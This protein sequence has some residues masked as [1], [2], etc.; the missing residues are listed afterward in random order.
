MPIRNFYPFKKAQTAQDLY[1]QNNNI[2]TSADKGFKD[3]NVKGSKPIEI[4]D[5][6]EYKL[7]EIND[8]GVF[9][10]PSP[11]AKEKPAFFSRTSTSTTRSHRS[12]LSDNEPFNISRESFDSYRR[13]FDISA[14]SPVSA[15][16]PPLR[17]SLDSRRN[18]NAYSPRPSFQ[19]RERASF[20]QSRDTPEDRFEDVGLNDE[21]K[22]QKKRGLFSR[23]GEDRTEPVTSEAKPA[24]AGTRFLSG[25]TGGR[26][27]GQSGTGSELA[28]MP[29]AVSVEAN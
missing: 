4:G 1:E 15:Y 12:L 19:D 13:S 10:P 5:Q 23:F 11:S 18:L 17:Q 24:T 26:K 16:E 20:Q 3:A 2:R 21:P 6:A 29:H 9:L 8:S 22:Q 27:R 28:N 7:S 14:R 25:I